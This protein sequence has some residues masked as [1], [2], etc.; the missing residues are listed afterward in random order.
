MNFFS[1]KKKSV[2]FD[3]GFKKKLSNL[4]NKLQV[5]V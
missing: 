1:K 4:V 3:Y 2:G 5:M